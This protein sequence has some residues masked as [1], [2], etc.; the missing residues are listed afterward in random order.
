MPK[1]PGSLTPASFLKKPPDPTPFKKKRGN[2]RKLSTSPTL[3]PVS[4]PRISTTPPDKTG[5]NSPTAPVISPLLPY[6]LRPK[7]SSSISKSIKF[8]LSSSLLSHSMDNILESGH[9]DIVMELPSADEVDALLHEDSTES[10]EDDADAGSFS[11][12]SNADSPTAA[13]KAAIEAKMNENLI[14]LDISPNFVTD[15]SKKDSNQA[16]PLPSLSPSLQAPAPLSKW[17]PPL[18]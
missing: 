10:K 7:K 9:D 12:L 18:C 14:S 6:Q 15:A 8:S 16:V 17:H 3:P 4:K 1:S 2:K 11:P 13:V 5:S